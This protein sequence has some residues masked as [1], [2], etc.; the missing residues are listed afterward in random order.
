MATRTPYS[1]RTRYVIGEGRETRTVQTF[2]RLNPTILA[3]DMAPWRG[4]INAVRVEEQPAQRG[5]Y[6]IQDRLTR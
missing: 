4:M 3:A 5:Y 2:T 6:T 1:A